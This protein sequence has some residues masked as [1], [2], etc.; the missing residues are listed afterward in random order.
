[1]GFVFRLEKVARHRQRLVDEQ[2]R[3]VAAA[4]RVVTGLQVRLAA[5]TEDIRCQVADFHEET[6][7]SVS[8][9]DMIARTMWL[10][11]LEELRD[12]CEVDLQAARIE[13]NE[14]Q[15]RLRTAWRELEVLNKLRDRQKLAW[16]A[17]QT[18]REVRDLDEIGQIRG[19]R[20]RRS[21]VA[22]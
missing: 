15:E 12:Q 3:Q 6:A 8:V 7:A 18:K 4:G 22:S 21:K 14:Q 9:Q 13:L 19:E 16:Q 20:Q 11:H 1:M 10:S 5:I 17:V 2:G